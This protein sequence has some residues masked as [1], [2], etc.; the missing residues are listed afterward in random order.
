MY[1][2][3]LA[4]RETQLNAQPHVGGGERELDEVLV[5][6]A[7]FLRAVAAVEALLALR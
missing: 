2:P 3:G 4:A 1:S 6:I 5:E 7:H